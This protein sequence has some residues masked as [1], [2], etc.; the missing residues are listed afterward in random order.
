VWHPEKSEAAE[1][2]EEVVVSGEHGGRS[3][4][5]TEQSIRCMKHT[6]SFSAQE[7]GGGSC[8]AERDVSG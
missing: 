4:D 8:A 3:W 6:P 1:N 7:V 5:T 2:S